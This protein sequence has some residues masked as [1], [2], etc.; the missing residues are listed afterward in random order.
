M[1]ERSSFGRGAAVVFLLV[2]VAFLV[3]R[4]YDG[5]SEKI[6]TMDATLVTIEELVSVDGTFI[7]DQVIVVGKDGDAEYMVQN[8]E[9]VSVGQSLC[10]FFDNES[11]A[12]NY[13]KLKD[14]NNSIDAL[15][16]IDSITNTGTDGVKLDGLVYSQL[17]SLLREIN[18]GSLNKLGKEYATLKQLV[19]A[20]DAGLYDHSL[21]SKKIAELENEAN[22]YSTAVESASDTVVSDYSGYFIVQAD[23]FES[24]FNKAYIDSVTSESLKSNRTASLDLPSN[25][26]GAIINDFY[27][28]VAFT[29]SVEQASS[30]EQIDKQLGGVY[31]YIPNISSRAERFTVEK[32]AREGMEKA[33][34]VLK[35]PVMTA[36]YLSTRFQ[37]V[38]LV[39][40][41]YKGIRVPIDAIHQENGEWGVYCLEG[42]SAK[43]KKVKIIYQTDNYYL[44]EMAESSSKG[45]YLY[46]KIILGGKD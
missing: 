7:R 10:I 2:F 42:A 15:K 26:V 46:D 37:T 24:V 16:Y 33:V 22:Q 34:V 20:R 45:L 3:F 35:S 40:G 1:K 36:D 39:L 18:N 25:A 31:A 29:V 17:D 32:V 9:K 11:A 44:L 5:L 21:F 4:V 30:L 14:L 41:T 28:Y 38:D 43:F 19:V 8:G 13:Q 27:W 23:G 12:E 6:T